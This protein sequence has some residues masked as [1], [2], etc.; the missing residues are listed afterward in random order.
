[1]DTVA[2][3]VGRASRV[4]LFPGVAGVLNCAKLSAFSSTWAA[5]SEA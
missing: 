5:K 2:I 3:S 4:P 1:M